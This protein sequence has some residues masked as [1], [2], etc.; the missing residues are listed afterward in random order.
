MIDNYP[1]K[2][3]TLNGN[4]IILLLRGTIL[5]CTE[6]V[7][8]SESSIEIPLE[9]IKIS[10]LKKFNGTRLTFALLSLVFVPGFFYIIYCILKLYNKNLPFS[11]AEF[12]MRAAIISSLI[13]FVILL[14]Y[15]FIKQ[16]NILMEFT[17]IDVKINFWVQ[18]KNKDKIYELIDE[19]NKRQKNIEN[20][21]LFPT[22]IATFDYFETSW[23]KMLVL[24][25][26]ISVP[27]MILENVWL[28][29]PA[30]IP[31]IY[32]IYISILSLRCPKKI[33]RAY[34]LFNNKQWAEAV[35]CVDEILLEFPDFLEI[36]LFK[37]ELMLRLNKF[38]EADNILAEIE[39]E[40]DTELLQKVQHEIII[41]QRIF[42]RQKNR[43]S[44]SSV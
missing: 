34:K 22:N 29:I 32:F 36:K 18:K 12:F 14:S 28:L 26:F 2:V 20:V 30:A 23:K 40:L 27:A 38:D 4:T 16:K 44:I 8:S 21:M 43:Q 5:T 33:R 31:V 1:I 35:D 10:T 39:S 7:W 17:N 41:R 24:S 19:I 11:V 3:H 13:V 15:F 6:K 9:F 37:I 42:Q 25:F